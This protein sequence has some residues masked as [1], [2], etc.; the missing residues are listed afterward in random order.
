LLREHGPNYGLTLLADAIAPG[1][2]TIAEFGADHFMDQP[3]IDAKTLA[4]ARALM[5]VAR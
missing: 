2:V 3:G 1:G 5:R 4:L